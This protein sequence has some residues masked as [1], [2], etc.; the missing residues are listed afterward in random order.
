MEFKN[1]GLIVEPLQPEDYLL[2]SDQSL[3]AKYGAD[4]YLNPTGDWTPYTPSTEDQDTKTGDTWAC[5]SF[6]T[7][8]A[9]EML[10]RIRFGHSLNLSDRYLAKM[11]GTELGKGNSPKTVAEYLKP[12]P[13]LRNHYWT[14][15]EKDWPDVETVEDYYIQPKDELKTLAVALGSQYEFGY[16]HVP[17]T[18]TTIKAALR[19]SPVCIAVTAWVE[20]NGVYVRGPFP[21]NHWTTIIK[22]LD[23]GNYLCFDSFY[24][25]LKEVKPEACQSIAMS[26][27]LNKNT[28][29]DSLFKKFIKAILAYFTESQ[30]E[31]V[32]EAPTPPVTT[33]PA[34]EP[35][36]PKPAGD[37]KLIAALIQVESGGNDNAIGDKNLTHK[38][39]GCLQI[40]QPFCDDVNRVY[41]SKLKAQDMLGNRALSID[42]VRKYWT[43]YKCKTDE[44]KAR[45]VN[46]GPSAKRPGSAQYKATNGYWARVK[47]RL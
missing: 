6:G 28:V 27:Y 10:A 17:N 12:R 23:N 44:E 46:G 41:G 7:T 34:P 2:G 24:P 19:T 14:V 31:S 32:T 38:A 1:Y 35:E 13:L 9:I 21:E 11:S 47:A 15:N 39:Y 8:N 30:P 5:T 33:P 40:R 25:F 4:V 45:V 36:K 26:Y 37:E 29:S 43:I 20:D 3:G 22:V 18:P 42:T 16:Q